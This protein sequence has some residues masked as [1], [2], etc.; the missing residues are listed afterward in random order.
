MDRIIS[1]LLCLC[2]VFTP[3]CALAD[4]GTELSV[5]YDS[6]AQRVRLSGFSLGETDIVLVSFG[7]YSDFVSGIKAPLDFYTF[8]SYGRFIYS[9]KM[10]LDAPAGKY[11]IY[12]TGKNGTAIADFMYF[13]PAEA[14]LL[15]QQIN[16][17]ES[18][19]G[20][21]D[22]VK[23]NA[24]ALGFDT[25]SD[26][27][28]QNVEAASELLFD[29]NVEFSDSVGFNKSFFKCLVIAAMRGS[30]AQETENLLLE[31]EAE[32]GIDYKSDYLENPMYSA[33]ERTALAAL[34]GTV[35]YINE[36]QLVREEIETAEFPEVLDALG[37][38]AKIKSASGYKAMQNVYE[39]H[40]SA[41]IYGNQDYN[42]ALA[43]TVFGNMMDMEF[44]TLS[45][46]KENFDKAVTIANTKKP[47]SSGGGGG[48]SASFSPTGISNNTYDEVYDN[49][50]ETAADEKSYKLPNL[51]YGAQ[52]SF[53]DLAPEHWSYAAVSAMN[54]SGYIDGYSDGSFKPS[55]DITRAEFVKMITAVF[56]MTGKRDTLFSDVIPDAWYSKYIA[57]AVSYGITNGYDGKFFPEAHITRQ[58]A[59]V[60]AYRCAAALGITYSGTYSFD[61]IN[62]ASTY[63]WPAIF[64]LAANGVIKGDE[65]NNVNPLSNIS[66]AEAAQLLFSLALDVSE[67]SK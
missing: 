30:T 40:C 5:N 16:R 33:K 38:L 42:S 15:V 24:A 45:D 10:P 56:S 50:A 54:Q 12:L 55:S 64:S 61:D 25:T 9:F 22:F 35:D 67:K 53:T 37:I 14:N 7:S 58:D 6:A 11:E 1:L 49:N 47:T 8:R 36:L 43:K 3:L 62:N 26:L 4:A 46:I 23:D 13:D 2:L 57:A 48:S 18:L 17:I 66:R 51:K 44:D 21:I 34:L 27:Y 20:Y 60:M 31:Y 65:K 32:L 39:Q 59:I 19:G 28:A 52:S 63:A 41:I 29:L